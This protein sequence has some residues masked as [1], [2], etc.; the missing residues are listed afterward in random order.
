[1]P[2]GIPVRT[3]RELFRNLQAWN[4]L[5]E[6]N[7]LDTIKGPDGEEYCLHDVV[8]LYEHAVPR[9]SERQK[10]AIELFLIQNR[11]ERE[12]ARLMGVSENNPVASYATQGMVRINAMIESGEVPGYS[13]DA[14][15][16]QETV[17]A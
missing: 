16:R 1:M 4:S 8:H 11:P 6:S 10:Q 2:T 7:G 17:A 15:A 12:V 13:A 3:M 9:L 5:Y 14:P